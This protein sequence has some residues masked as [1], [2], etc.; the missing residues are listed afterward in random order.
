[1]LEL[2][3]HKHFQKINIF[4]F[5][6]FMIKKQANMINGIKINKKFI[7]KIAVDLQLK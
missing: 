6:K 1:M 3:L 4:Y 5:K 2:H 7:K